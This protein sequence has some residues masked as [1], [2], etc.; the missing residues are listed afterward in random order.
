MRPLLGQILD[1]RQEEGDR[2]AVVT[3]CGDDDTRVDEGAVVAL[4]SFL[5]REL[6][7][8]AGGQ[9]LEQHE[10]VRQI[11]SER[12]I[13]ERHRQQLFARKAEERAEL[14]VD[15]EE[16]A[17]KIEMRD[18]HRRSIDRHGVARGG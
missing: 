18:A 16:S 12:N 13:L 6:R 9:L 17:L 3:H 8:G 1:D 5:V 15:E 7:N 10:A 11:L 14:R 4:E 2:A